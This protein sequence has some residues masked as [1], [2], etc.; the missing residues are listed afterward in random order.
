[1]LTKKWASY[2]G[3]GSSVIRTEH[4][5]KKDLENA[6]Q[7]VQGSWDVHFWKKDLLKHVPSSLAKGM[8]HPIKGIKALARFMK[9]PAQ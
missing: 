2:D 1:L 7:E 5:S 4:L 3:S 6:L 9:R 8:L